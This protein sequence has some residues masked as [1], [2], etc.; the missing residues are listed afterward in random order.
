LHL[1]ETGTV[2]AEGTFFGHHRGAFL[3]N[4]PT[5]RSI[6]FRFAVVVTFRDGL[7]AGE[8]FYYDRLSLLEQ[9]RAPL[10]E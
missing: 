2:V 9:L 4:P 8:K 5:G 3:D 1:T 7:M 10:K 6:S